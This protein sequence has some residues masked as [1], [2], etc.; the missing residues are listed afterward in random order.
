MKDFYICDAGQFENQV[1]TSSFVVATKQ[2]KPKKSGE[3]YLALTVA[4]RTGQLEAKMWDNVNEHIGSF[5]QDDFV[6]I[7]GLLNKFNGRFQRAVGWPGA[8]H[9]IDDHIGQ[10]QVV[11]VRRRRGGREAGDVGAAVGQAAF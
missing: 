3:L 4:D 1:I 2:V 7:R 11:R 6:K 8:Q 9:F 10:G 5:D